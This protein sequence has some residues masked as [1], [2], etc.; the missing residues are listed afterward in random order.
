MVVIADPDH[1][2][3][4]N[5]V[6]DAGDRRHRTM[7]TFDGANV[8]LVRSLGTFWR[9]QTA[10][11]LFSALFGIVSRV[12]AFED[13]VFALVLTAILE[14]LGFALTTL[15][16][17]VFRDRTVSI[18]LTV[19]TVALVLSIAGGLL[20]MFVANTIKEFLLPGG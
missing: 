20:Q 19:V 2:G 3:E 13:I 14:P 5:G 4:L 18:T 9:A 7:W 11:W 17:R 6:A 10:G 15:A 1:R 12:L 16:H 8:E